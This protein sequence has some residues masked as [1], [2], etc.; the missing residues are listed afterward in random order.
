MQS[1]RW[2]VAAGGAGCVAA[3][4]AWGLVD[5]VASNALATLALAPTLCMLL[6]FGGYAMGE[7]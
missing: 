2:R 3:V 1:S 6:A 4:A 5:M 7:E